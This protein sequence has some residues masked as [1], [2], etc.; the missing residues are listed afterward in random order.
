MFSV[1]YLVFE[2][3]K[4]LFVAFSKKK[5]HFAKMPIKGPITQK[6]KTNLKL[7]LFWKK[8]LGCNLV[9]LTSI[10]PM[11]LKPK[12]MKYFHIATVQFV[13]SIFS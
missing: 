11:L 9:E 8:T 5:N 12:V 4:R 3:K 1:T 7:Y 6:I 10:Y 2:R 13:V